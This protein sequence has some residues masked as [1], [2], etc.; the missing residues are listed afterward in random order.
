MP[1][2][3][4]QIECFETSAYIIQVPMKM[5]EIECSETS[6]YIIQTPGNYPKENNIKPYIYLPVQPLTHLH[7]TNPSAYPPSI[8]LKTTLPT[9]A[10]KSRP[11]PLTQLQAGCCPLSHINYPR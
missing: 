3:M 8:Q 4:E 2:K 11:V 7:S 5:E 1:M 9:D 6:T 10:A